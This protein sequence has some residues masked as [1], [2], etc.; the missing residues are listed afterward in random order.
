M[1]A[2][3]LGLGGGVRGVVWE[4]RGA[5][6]AETQTIETHGRAGTGTGSTHFVHNNT[7]QTSLAQ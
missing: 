5:C 6:S 4:G 2:L 3:G 1:G 7:R